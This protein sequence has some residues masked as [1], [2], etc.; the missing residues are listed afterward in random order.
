MGHGIPTRRKAVLADD[1]E[2]VRP[3]ERCVLD[4]ASVIKVPQGM[5]GHTELVNQEQRVFFVVL[6]LAMFIMCS[7]VNQS[8]KSMG[9]RQLLGREAVYYPFDSVCM[10]RI[11]QYR[12]SDTPYPCCLDSASGQC[13]PRLISGATAWKANGHHYS[14]LYCNSTNSDHRKTVS[15]G[16]TL[17]GNL[18]G[19][20]PSAMS[21]RAKEQKQLNRHQIFTPDQR[22]HATGNSSPSLLGRRASDS[23]SPRQHANSRFPTGPGAIDPTA[24]VRFRR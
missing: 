10:E 14:A 5:V 4:F 8:R 20:F 9:L 23:C 24:P 11:S 15:R 17:H 12:V 19:D 3:G 13:R 6:V 1:W 7:L 21:A 18:L 16:S 22:F 2:R